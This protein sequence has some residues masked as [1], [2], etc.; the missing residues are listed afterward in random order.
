MFTFIFLL[1]GC[2]N[3]GEDEAEEKDWTD[4]LVKA[5]KVEVS[6]AKEK[7]LITVIEEPPSVDK[8]VSALQPDRWK[9][10]DIPDNA[11]P[12]KDFT[13]YQERTTKLGESSDGPTTVK[14]V[15]KITTY[16]DIPYID[17]TIHNNIFGFEVTEDIAE[18]L[19]K[20]GGE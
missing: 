11:I 17:F 10:A 4:G 5:Q 8:F 6:L 20:Q 9:L 13:M 15:A 16:K 18:Y 1:T 7:K 3:N 14:E 2:E 12:E 19:A